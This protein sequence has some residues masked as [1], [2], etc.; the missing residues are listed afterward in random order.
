MGG[1][2]K[3]LRERKAGEPYRDASGDIQDQDGGVVGREAHLLPQTAKIC[4]HEER[5]SQN[6]CCKL[7][8]DLRLLK[9]QENLHVTGWEK[10]KKRNWGETCAPGREL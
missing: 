7:A 6:F 1:R 3:I 9:G 4:L 5:F 8:E 10:R 2:N